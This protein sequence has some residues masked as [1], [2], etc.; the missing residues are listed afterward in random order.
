MR[1]SRF[2]MWALLPIAMLVVLTSTLA[3]SSPAMPNTSISMSIAPSPPTAI[4]PGGQES[5]QWLIVPTSTPVSVTFSIVDLDNDILL[6]QQSFPG[7]TGLSANTAFTLPLS[8]VLPFGKQFERY[9]GRIEYF[10]DEAG[11]EAGAE[12]IFWVTQDTGNIHVIKFD[13]RNGNGFQDAG[14]PGVGNIRFGLTVQG[15]TLFKPTDSAGEIRWLD[16]PIGTYTV[17]EEVPLGYVATT[18]NPAAAV[19]TADATTELLFGNRIIPG[20]LEAFVFVDVD[21][22]GTQD[23]GDPPYQ[24]AAVGFLSP[25]G[26]NAS[27]VTDNTGTI[28]WPDR[29]VGAYAVNLSVPAGYAATTPTGVSRTVTSSV[30]SRVDYG[31]QGRGTLVAAK[32]EDRN[33]N[34]LQDT[35]EGALDGVTMT[36]TG[37]LSGGA[38]QTA[39]GLVVW[40]DVPVGQYAVSEIVPAS[41][42]ATTPTSATVVLNPGQVATTTFGNLLLGNLV[43][44]VFED[45]NQNGIWDPGEVPLAGVTVTWGSEYGASAT[46]ITPPSGIVTWTGQPIGLYTVTQT[47]LVNYAATTPLS[48]FA[49]VLHNSTATVDFGQRQNTRCVEGRKIDDEH[50][51]MAGWA[52]RAQLVDGT[53]PIYATTSGVDGYFIFPALPLGS[54]RFW[55]IMQT[56]WSPVTPAEFEVPILEPGDQCLQIR[57]KNRLGPPLTASTSTTSYLPMVAGQEGAYH[58]R[59][60]RLPLAATA[61]PVGGGCVSGRKIDVLQAGLPG[62]VLD[63]MPLSGDGLTRSTTTNGLGDF[64]FDGVPPGDYTVAEAPKLGWINVSPAQLDVTVSAG[65]R[66]SQVIFE[67]RQATPTPTPTNTPTRTPTPTPTST[68]THTPTATP[69]STD[70]PTPTPELI[71]R[72]I[73]EPKGIGVN[74]QTNQLFIA[75]KSTD[76]VYKVDAGTNQVLTFWS[77]GREPFGVG[78]NRVTGKVYVANYA[79]DTLT[80][81]AGATGVLLGTVDFAPYGQPSYVAVN[82]VTNRVYVTLHAGGRLAV[83]DGDTNG[84]ITTV[85]VEAGAFDVAL[86]PGLHRAYVSARDAHAV[87]VIDTATN[88]RLWEETIPVESSPY[89]VAVDAG[90]NQLYVFNGAEDGEPTRV[91]VYELK[92]TGASK[93]GSV[94]VG[95]GGAAG[96]T[97]LVVNP[98][99]GHVF[100][101]NSAD[102]S[103]TVFDGATRGV[104]ATI[105]VGRDPG[106]AGVNPI[107]NRVYVSNRGDNT[108]QTLLDTYTRRTV[109]R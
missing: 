45:E 106:M 28:L 58:A 59:Q 20:A 107:T 13:D 53:G 103:V 16:V 42:R 80:I 23:A 67:N 57:F 8:Y 54:Y 61:T 73:P 86:H 82:E 102:D 10:S 47:V 41:A 5:F 21:G 97:G 43:A 9:V 91:A 11:Y 62:F 2:L 25:C 14:E 65:G 100:A 66:C 55:E 38:G 90:R 74:T 101:V 29:C 77:T 68:P 63:L 40:A 34:G 37:T 44:R 105:A 60:A 49:T 108:V 88:T 24:G 96:G 84:L 12:A 109:R 27:A 36:Y 89:A 71:I 33:G 78:V 75:S 81:F 94:T 15:Q 1:A 104:L 39:A 92:G 18:P 79:S 31:I 76:R 50:V 87:V 46:G 7:A 19:V 48:R 3:A 83:V 17:T 98:T 35:G 56:G 99:T 22:R 26:D 6:D 32:F 69:T 52:I 51:G 85:A 72:G 30:T 93:I 64:R 95:K 4:K 70:T